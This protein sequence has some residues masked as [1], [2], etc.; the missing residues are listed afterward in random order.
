[1]LCDCQYV[2]LG[3]YL[4]GAEHCAPRWRASRTSLH[5]RLHCEAGSNRSGPTGGSAYGMSP[6]TATGASPRN[7]S[8]PFCQRAHPHSWVPSANRRG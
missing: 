3:S 1:M 7:E 8:V 5:G 2:P 6:N 4:S